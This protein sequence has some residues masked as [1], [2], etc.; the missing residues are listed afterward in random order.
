MAEYFGDDHIIALQKEIRAR[1]RVIS[2][3]PLLSNGGRIIN[4]LDPD[5]Y[6]WDNVRTDAKRYGFIGLTMVDRDKTLARLAREFGPEIS[7]PYWDAFKGAPDEVLSACEKALADFTLSDGWTLTN[8]THPEDET[9][10]QSQQLNQAS[11]VAPTPA[12]YLRGDYMPSM[13]TCLHDAQGTL[14]ACASATMRYHPDG[15]LSGWLFAGAV[16]VRPEHRRKGLGAYVNAALLYASQKAFGWRNVLEQA[17]A[18]NPASVGM[19]T[20]CG[21]QHM[22]G[23]ATIVVNTTGGYLT[24]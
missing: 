8:L 11:G 3:E 2:N 23:L 1:A 19:I 24:R 21:L 22:P 6:G 14:A 12:Y 17:K 18:D 5:A 16:S 9:I 7:T 15:P 20:R 13:L 4:I 10:D